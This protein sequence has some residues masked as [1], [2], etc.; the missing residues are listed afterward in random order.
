MS[1]DNKSLIEKRLRL[2]DSLNNQSLIRQKSQNN[3]NIFDKPKFKKIAGMDGKIKEFDQKLSDCFDKKAR[4]LIKSC[5]G[6]LVQDNPDEYAEDMIIYSKDIPFG[7]MEL[8]VHGSWKERDFPYPNPFVYERKMKF[9]ASTLFICLNNE[10]TEA[11]VFSRTAI[12]PEK[13]RLEKYSREL[14]HIVPWNRV[15]RIPVKQLN[16]KTLINCYGDIE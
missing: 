15:Y 12:S 6:E 13:Q 1:G 14:I 5:F 16:I 4:D 3:K 7:Y 11:L 2:F 9:C 10:M 8:Q